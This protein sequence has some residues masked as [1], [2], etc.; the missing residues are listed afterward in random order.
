MWKIQRKKNLEDDSRTIDE[1]Y[2][3]LPANN[4]A[5]ISSDQDIQNMVEN[6]ENDDNKANIKNK[7]RKRVKKLEMFK[8]FC[9]DIVNKLMIQQEEMHNKHLL[10]VSSFSTP[11]TKNPNP[12]VYTYM[13]GFGSF[14]WQS[15]K[16][17]RDIRVA[18]WKQ[19]VAA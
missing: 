12:I 15:T 3:T 9:E 7:K 6:K 1:L 14:K 11:V 13:D 18:S 5:T 2:Q 16:E 4:D 8:G 17:K 10:A 19:V